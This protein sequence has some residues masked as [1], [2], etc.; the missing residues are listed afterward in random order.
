KV[1]GMTCNHC[2]ANVENGLNEL[3]GIYVEAVDL[4]TS[5]VKIKGVN[6]DHK[7]VKDTVESLGYS[8]KGKVFNNFKLAKLETYKFSIKGMTCNHCKANVENALMQVS[9][10]KKVE[11]NIGNSIAVIV[12]T[13]INPDEIKNIIEGVGYEY[14]GLVN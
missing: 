10:V 7:L 11:A 6:I 3:T 12:G 14:G 4:K 1:E 9:G 8:Y 2:K 13:N 5:T